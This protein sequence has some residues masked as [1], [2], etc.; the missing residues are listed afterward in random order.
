[1]VLGGYHI[2]KGTFCIRVS[3]TATDSDYFRYSHRKSLEERHLILILY[4]FLIMPGEGIL[5]LVFE[6]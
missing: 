2:P 4:I 3:A 6:H 1:M 5:I